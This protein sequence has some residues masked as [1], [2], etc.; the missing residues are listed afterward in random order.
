VRDEGVGIAPEFLPHIFERFRQADSR[1]TRTYGGLGLGLAIARHLVELHGGAIQA[2]S[3]GLGH[4]ATVTIALPLV[5]SSMQTSI[6]APAAA[7]ADVRLDGLHVLVVDDQQDSCELVAM[8][9]ERHGA[10]VAACDSAAHAQARLQARRFDLLIADIAMPEIDGYRLIRDVRARGF[11][12]PAIAFTAYARPDDRRQ[13]LAAGYSAY[14]AKP[15]DGP[16]LLQ[17]I[18]E[19]VAP[20]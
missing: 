16:S 9:L 17:T 4:G 1:S 15:I 7:G 10:A 19:L 8:L 20:S 5:A 11:T 6:V 18:R 12:L 3:A 14:C 13:A 2:E